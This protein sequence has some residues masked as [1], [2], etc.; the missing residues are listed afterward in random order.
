MMAVTNKKKTSERSET[1]WNRWNQV[2]LSEISETSETAWDQWPQWD[3]VR[4]VRTVRAHPPSQP[5]PPILLSNFSWLYGYFDIAWHCLTYLH[6]FEYTLNTSLTQ[7]EYISIQHILIIVASDCLFVLCVTTD[8]RESLM[9]KLAEAHGW[10]P[11]PLSRVPL[12]LPWHPMRRWL[13]VMH[14]FVYGFPLLAYV[15]FRSSSSHCF[16]LAAK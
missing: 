15:F 16:S 2:R 14:L 9:R 10:Q 13:A 1:T 3:S 5:P 7:F 4:P 12:C 11:L 8:W 6:T